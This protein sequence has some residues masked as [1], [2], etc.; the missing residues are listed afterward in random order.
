MEPVKTPEPRQRE[1][2]EEH[3]QEQEHMKH[4]HHPRCFKW[5]AWKASLRSKDKAS[6]PSCQASGKEVR[7]IHHH[8]REYR[9]MV[10]ALFAREV[11]TRPTLPDRHTFHNRA[12]RPWLQ[13]F[14]QERCASILSG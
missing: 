1:D 2:E 11:Q 4:H 12:E 6:L 9:S 8:E 13:A 5:E 3:E 10:V 14:C 7:I